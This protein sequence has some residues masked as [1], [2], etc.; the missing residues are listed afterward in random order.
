M[1]VILRWAVTDIDQVDVIDVHWWRGRRG[2]EGVGG[3]DRESW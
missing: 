2:D 3:D 1:S